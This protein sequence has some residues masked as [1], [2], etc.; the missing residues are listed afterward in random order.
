MQFLPDSPF[1]AFIESIE[2]TPWLGYLNWFVPVGTF[3]GIGTLWVAAII[4][5]YV[6]QMIF[7]WAKVVG[8]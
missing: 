8:D 6:Y 3:V 2:E 7:R 1:T 5:F 4:V